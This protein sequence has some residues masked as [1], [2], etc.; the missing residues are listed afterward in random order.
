MSVF[1]ITK[2]FCAHAIRLRKLH[3]Q[4]FILLYVNEQETTAETQKMPK[5]EDSEL[6]ICCNFSHQ[7]LVQH[8]PIFKKVSAMF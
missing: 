8:F 6:S 5:V 1:I 3:I 7:I 2:Q 4:P